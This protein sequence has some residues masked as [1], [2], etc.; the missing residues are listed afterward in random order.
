MRLTSYVQTSALASLALAALF[1]LCTVWSGCRSDQMRAQEFPEARLRFQL[2]ESWSVHVSRPGQAP[3]PLEAQA[4]AAR[5]GAVVTALSALEDAALV[6]YA[7]Q[8]EVEVTRF[9][10]YMKSFVPLQDTKFLPEDKL[11]EGTLNGLPVFRGQG[12]GKLPAD[13]T[14]VWFQSLA[15]DVEGQPVFVILYVEASQKERYAKTFQE[16]ED[17]LQPTFSPRVEVKVP[18]APRAPASPEARPPAPTSPPPIAPAPPE[19]PP[20]APAPQGEVAPPSPPQD[21]PAAPQESPTGPPEEPSERAPTPPPSPD[22]SAPAGGG[23]PA[24]PPTPSPPPS[25]DPATTLP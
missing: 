6:I 11:V 5:D 15:I 1:V 4:P 18:A 21:A 23:P 22:P 10:R 2:P 3:S 17:S 8:R 9:A 24:P 14:E 25:P 12:T 13:Q 7:P 19:G 20:E 16:I